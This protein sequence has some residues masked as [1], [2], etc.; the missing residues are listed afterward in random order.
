MFYIKEFL[1]HLREK[2]Y[3]YST[4]Q[5]YRNDLEHFEA[6]F[7]YH[8]DVRNISR[9]QIREYLDTL[10]KKDHP[11]KAYCNRITR[12]IK[13]FRYLEEEGIIFLS[14]LSDVC[15]P[16]Y[17]KKSYTVIE[18]AEMEKILT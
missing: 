15:I 1:K 6:Y 7:T 12:I 4:L 18:K 5:D 9:R 3:C 16:K 13:Y 8:E 10:N 2:H 14:P 11:T 17:H